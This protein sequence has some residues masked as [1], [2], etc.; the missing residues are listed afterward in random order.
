[1][2]LE[3][4]IIEFQDKSTL[5]CVAGCGKCYANPEINASPLEFLPWAF[6]LFLNGK[7]ETV[8]SVLF[9][10]DISTCYIFNPLSLLEINRGNCSNYQYRGL[11]CRL[12]GFGANKDK[13]ERYRLSTCKIIKDGQKEAFESTS[14]AINDGLAVPIFTDYYMRL[15]QIDFRLGNII[16]PINKAL[17]FAIQEVLQYYAYRPMPNGYN[18]CA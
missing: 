12:F 1:M 2:Q 3:L 7:A 6:Y 17:I 11:I 13:Y 16:L 10:T 14:I 4:E 9:K 15:S 8:L 5:R 18:N